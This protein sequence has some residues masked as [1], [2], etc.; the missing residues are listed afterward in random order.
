MKASAEAS[1]LY[2][3]G[4][5]VCSNPVLMCPLL[6]LR[7]PSLNSPQGLHHQETPWSSVTGVKK[8]VG[9]EMAATLLMVAAAAAR[10]KADLMKLTMLIGGE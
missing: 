8:R 1:A 10:A 7:S 4:N 6:Q 5:V 2:S 3:Q 9:I